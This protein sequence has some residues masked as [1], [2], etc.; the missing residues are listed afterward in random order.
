V[1]GATQLSRRA[2][3]VGAALGLAGCRSRHPAAPASPSPSAG[4]DAAAL[5]AARESEA[6]LL[7]SY[8]AAIGHAHPARR[9]GLV[10]VRAQHQAHLAALGGGRSTPPAGTVEPDLAAAT[11][12]SAAG[13]RAAAIAA[14]SGSTAALLASIAAAHQ[15]D[16]T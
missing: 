1:P 15:A 2:I 16:P 12:A 11:R 8:D 6:T 10:A 3:L 4:P 5:A 9:A 13:L 14:R 7:A